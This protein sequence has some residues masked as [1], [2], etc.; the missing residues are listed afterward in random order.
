M[1]LHIWHYK[2]IEKYQEEHKKKLLDDEAQKIVD[3]IVRHFKLGSYYVKFYGSGDGGRI[4]S[5]GIVRL[6][7]NPSFAL[8]CHELTH[9]LVWKRYNHKP[10]S[11]NNKK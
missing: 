3:K 5:N 4:W 6:S 7:H 9:P 10:I 8:I 1:T 2:E 11:H